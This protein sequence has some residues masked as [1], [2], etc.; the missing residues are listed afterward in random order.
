MLRDHLDSDKLGDT[1]KR[2]SFGFRQECATFLRAVL[3]KNPH[4]EV[5]GAACL[6]LAQFLAGQVEKLDLMKEQPELARRYEGLYGKDYI[7]AL[8]QRDRAQAMKEAEALYDQAVEKYGDVKLPY[9]ETAGEVAS[10]DLFEIRHLAVGK[11]A[12]DL[13]GEDQEGQPFKL[14]DY[15]GK[16][17]LLYFWSEY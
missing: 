15:R 12:L 17:V 1:C 11:V 14:S 6:R 16:V 7:E 13:E 2:V 5:Q 8:R 4:R 3:E 9:N 10:T